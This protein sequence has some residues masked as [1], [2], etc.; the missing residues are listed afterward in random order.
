[1]SIAFHPDVEGWPFDRGDCVTEED[2]LW[3][4]FKDGSKVCLACD[5]RVKHVGSDR[6]K[7]GE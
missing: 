6:Q 1:M 2:H 3:E 4:R 5:A 7:V